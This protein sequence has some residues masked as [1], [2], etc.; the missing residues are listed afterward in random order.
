M[1]ARLHRQGQKDTVMIIHIS[2]GDVEDDLMKSLAQKDITQ[3]KL[4]EVLKDDV[5][6]P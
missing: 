6:L 4:L 3:A 2:V 1:N 5:K